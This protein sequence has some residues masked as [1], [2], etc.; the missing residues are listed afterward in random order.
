MEGGRVNNSWCNGVFS[1]GYGGL[2]GS[3]D[4]VGEW[5]AC[6]EKARGLVACREIPEHF[7]SVT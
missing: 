6:G 5:N 2:G 4:G 7:R 1:H 3:R